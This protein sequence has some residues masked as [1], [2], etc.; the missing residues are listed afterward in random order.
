MFNFEHSVSLMTASRKALKRAVIILGSQNKV[1]KTV[2]VTQGWISQMLR[3]DI[4]I[5]AE[6][7]AKLH[8]ATRGQVTRR[9]LRPDLF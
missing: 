4:Q 1:A 9:Q 8:R 5:P 3:R 7:C 2:G 6:W